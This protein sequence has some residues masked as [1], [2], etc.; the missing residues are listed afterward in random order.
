[1]VAPKR[2]NGSGDDDKRETNR[3]L[4]IANY[5]AEITHCMETIANAEQC[6]CHNCAVFGGEALI[7]SVTYVAAIEALEG[8]PEM[9]ADLVTAV[10]Q[11]A[12]KHRP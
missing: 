4:A 12:V 10:N 5:R 9:L 11:I 7:S 1:M 6:P 8:N 2:P 3:T